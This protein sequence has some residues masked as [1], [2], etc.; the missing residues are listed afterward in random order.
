MLIFKKAVNEITE[1]D[2]IRKDN[3]V[4]RSKTYYK[5]EIKSNETFTK[6][7]YLHIQIDICQN[8]L[9]KRKSLSQ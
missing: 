2:S 5:F 7:T 8:L 9:I 4:S 1:G 6:N 3:F